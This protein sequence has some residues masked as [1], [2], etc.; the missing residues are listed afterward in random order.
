M[1]ISIREKD[2]FEE[3]IKFLGGAVNGGYPIVDVD[4]EDCGMNFMGK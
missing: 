3:E 2:Y 4:P 1:M